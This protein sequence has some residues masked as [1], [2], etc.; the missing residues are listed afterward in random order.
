[1]LLGT[2]LG[3]TLWTYWELERNM[4]GTKEK[5]N[6]PPWLWVGQSPATI[7][8]CVGLKKMSLFFLTFFFQ[9]HFTNLPTPFS[10]LQPL[11]LFPFMHFWSAQHSSVKCLPK[12]H[13]QLHFQHHHSFQC[14]LHC[15]IAIACSKVSSI[16]PLPSPMSPCT[17]CT[18]PSFVN[19]LDFALWCKRQWRLS[20]SSFLCCPS[21][22]NND[23]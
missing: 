9:T 18:L 6:P 22:K 4:L 23:E 3:N 17:F 10:G 7:S 2:P 15:A 14:E 1:V 20:S 19:F 11:F 5:W 13:A 21:T 12:Q 16:A 8:F